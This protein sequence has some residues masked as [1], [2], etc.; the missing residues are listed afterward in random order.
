MS[1]PWCSGVEE[2]IMDEE[3]VY[4]FFEQ[5]EAWMY[6]PVDDFWGYKWCGVYARIRGRSIYG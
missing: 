4:D 6:I 2:P 5:R 1:R 3:G